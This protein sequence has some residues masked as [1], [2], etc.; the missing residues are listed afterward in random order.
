MFLFCLGLRPFR[1]PFL[2]W[3]IKVLTPESLTVPINDFKKFIFDQN[4]RFRTK[5]SYDR[6]TIN[7]KWH[8]V[9]V[10][11]S[12]SEGLS[13][14]TASTS[15]E[16]NIYFDGQKVVSNQIG[17]MNTQTFDK[18]FTIGAHTNQNGDY[19]YTYPLYKWFKGSI[20][21][22]VVYNRVIRP[23][24]IETLSATSFA[25]VLAND[26]EVDGED[27][28]AT[29]VVDPNQGDVTLFNSNGIFSSPLRLRLFTLSK[30][31]V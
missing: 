8:N 30:Q 25:S 7:N 14:D 15:G 11:Y 26:I 27:L 17:D 21:D 31:I 23:D 1:I 6:Q 2:A 29:K 5:Y 20:D 10:T 12:T 4:Y 9:I 16:L 22:I 13:T 28:S 18:V 3:M 19:V 24:E